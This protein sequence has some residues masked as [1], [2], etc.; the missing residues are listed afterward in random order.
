MLIFFQVIVEV[1]STAKLQYCTE[2]IM[3]DLYG[4][5]MFDNAPIVELFMYLIFSQ[6]MLDIVILDLVTPAVIEMVYLACN[7]SA[8]FQIESFI[9]L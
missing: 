2:T 3:I 1:R 5:I 6:S 9:N 7:F 4:V 8:I